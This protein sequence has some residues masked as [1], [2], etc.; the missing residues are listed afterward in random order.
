M[1]VELQQVLCQLACLG[2]NPASLFHPGGAAQPIEAHGRAAQE[3]VHHADAV[4]R[5]IESTAVVL[6]V[7]K[8]VGHSPQGELLQAPVAS[9]PL[10]VVDHQVALGDFGQIPKPGRRGSRGCTVRARTKDLLF[11]D[12]RQALIGQAESAGERPD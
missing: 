4:D 11:R 3:P 9:H 12:Q 1:G 8:V 10:F 6:Q 7:E 5:H 2:G